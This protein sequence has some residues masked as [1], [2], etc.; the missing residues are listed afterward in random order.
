[1]RR[2]VFQSLLN[3]SLWF[4]GLIALLV[5]GWSLLLAF[6]NYGDQDVPAAVPADGLGGAL[7]GDSARGVAD[8]PAA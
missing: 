2:A 8:R 4:G 7:T 1:L 6:G 3:E 5:L